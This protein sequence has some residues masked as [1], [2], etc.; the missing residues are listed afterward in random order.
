LSG[1]SNF[2][3]ESCDRSSEGKTT[4]PKAFSL[5]YGLDFNTEMMSFWSWFRDAREALAGNAEPTTQVRELVESQRA[6]IER[7]AGAEPNPEMARFALTLA[8]ALVGSHYA[9]NQKLLAALQDYGLLQLP[10]QAT[11][12]R[13]IIEPALEEERPR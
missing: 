3:I 1:R 8:V 11:V 10:E 7:V 5:T 9:S 6:T 13:T 2:D 4:M 12:F